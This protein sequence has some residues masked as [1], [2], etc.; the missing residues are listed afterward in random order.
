[1]PINESR[2]GAQ[3]PREAF[4][5][6]LEQVG[7]LNW[8]KKIFYL[9]S[10]IR[11]WMNSTSQGE[12][13][14]N[15]VRLVSSFYDG[16]GFPKTT[17]N[18]C[19]KHLLVLAVLLHPDVNCGPLIDIFVRCNLS[20]DYLSLAD[21]SSYYDD[22][23]EDLT[24]EQPLLPE[25]YTQYDYKAVTR[26]FDKTRWAFCPARL[27]LHMNTTFP[28][29]PCI[30]PFLHGVVINKKGGTAN[31]RHYKIQEDI[32]ESETLKAALA[33]SRHKD[34]AFGWVGFIRYGLI[35]LH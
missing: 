10:D 33:S 26:A 16:N 25:S 13:F 19:T 22:I 6:H 18:D 14:T 32:V 34:P 4:L 12:T 35:T 29:G 31:V 15:V 11:A 17:A 27:N 3:S 2:A 21:P 23:L 24:K 5:H 28:S 1:M 7:R 30:L 20:D 9:P 8:E